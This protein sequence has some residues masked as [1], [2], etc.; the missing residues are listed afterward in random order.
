MGTENG[1]AKTGEEKETQQQLG[2]REG[3]RRRGGQKSE[4][5]ERN[6]AITVLNL[7]IL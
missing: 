7:G 1:D 2:K 4:G 6:A 5:T 3:T